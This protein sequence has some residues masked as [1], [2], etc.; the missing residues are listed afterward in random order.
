M[1]SPQ[2]LSI[3]IIGRHGQPLYM[4]NFTSQVGGEA[5]LK[6]YYAAHTSLDVFEERDALP[7][8]VMDTYFGLLYTMEDYACYGYQTNTKVRFVVC[9][10]LKEVL[11]KDTE[12]KALFRSLH[13]A[14][15][16]YLS[17]PF[18]QFPPENLT[19]LAPAIKSKKFDSLIDRIAG[20]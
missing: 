17:N 14:Y 4:R 9:L 13:S 20:V 1:P 16:H 11:V 3:T 12:V 10:G 2:I 8:K 7:T 6:W 15:I 19:T 5:D 18:V